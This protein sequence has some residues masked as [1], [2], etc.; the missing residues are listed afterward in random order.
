MK[1][2]NMKHQSVKKIEENE[3]I[4]VVDA[5]RVGGYFDRGPQRQ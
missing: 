3:Q 4:D 5:N 1:G 2:K